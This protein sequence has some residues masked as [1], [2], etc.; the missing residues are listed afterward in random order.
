M[1]D[2]RHD[3]AGF[4][5]RDPF[6]RARAQMTSVRLCCHANPHRTRAAAAVTGG[7]FEFDYSAAPRRSGQL[8]SRFRSAEEEGDTARVLSGDIHCVRRCLAPLRN[9]SFDINYADPAALI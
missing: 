5:S 3:C 1:V 7:S 6:T 8:K 4:G 9:M 2:G